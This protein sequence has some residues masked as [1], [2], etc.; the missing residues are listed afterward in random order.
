MRR[1]I[2][3]VLLALV[4]AACA[5]APQP[6]PAPTVVA[7]GSNPT[8]VPTRAPLP[9]DVPLTPTPGLKASQITTFIVSD[10]ALVA[11][12]GR[13]QVVEFFAQW[14]EQCQQMR[15]IMHALQDQYAAMVDFVYLDI[16]AD[17]TKELQRKMAFN[18]LRPTIV[19]LDANG[20]EKGRLIGVTPKEKVESQIEE[21][22]TVG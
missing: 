18:G 12:T 15:P 17:N 3:F 11:N 16:D 9:T 1:L 5:Q 13:P 4:V 22:L 7:Q 2:A 21:L 8:P 14:C 19:F 6:T 20:K 10:P